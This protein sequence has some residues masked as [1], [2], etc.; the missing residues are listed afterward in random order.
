MAKVGQKVTYRDV[1]RGK[2]IIGEVIAIV[3]IVDSRVKEDIGRKIC[4]LSEGDEYIPYTCFEEDVIL[5][6]E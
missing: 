5:M 1:L 6:E 2:D 4:Y 3:Q